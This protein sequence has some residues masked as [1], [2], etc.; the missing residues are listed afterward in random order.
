MPIKYGDGDLERTPAVQLT[1]EHMNKQDI[2]ILFHYNEWSTARIL[3][4]AAMLSQAQFLAS[5]PFPH[6]SLRAT[7]VHALFAEW[8]WRRRWE[9]FPR[10]SVLNPEDFPTLDALSERWAE[11]T[12]RLNDFVANVSEERLQSK[13]NYVSTE[14]LAH[15]RVMWESMAHV[16]NHGTQ[17]KTEAAAILTAFGHSPGDIDL[18]VYFN[19]GGQ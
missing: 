9:G 15:E 1:E 16:V 11:E 10:N 17:H 8:V 3:G 18:I 4:K 5:V 14:G 7:L 12:R 13:F 2:T 6:G 19:E